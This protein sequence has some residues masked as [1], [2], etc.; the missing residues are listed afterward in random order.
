MMSERCEMLLEKCKKVCF[1]LWKV[2]RKLS[3]NGQKVVRN[4][5]EKCQKI[6]VKLLTNC[7]KVARKL[8]EFAINLQERFQRVV[9]VVRKSS[10]SR[11]KVFILDIKICYSLSFVILSRSVFDQSLPVHPVPESRGS[12]KCDGGGTEIPVSNIG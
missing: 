2:V 7:R 10:E 8:Q 1:F 3:E 4:L 11:W 9:R 5:P 6:A 12:P